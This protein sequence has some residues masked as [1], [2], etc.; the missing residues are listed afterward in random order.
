MC[1][2]LDEAELID[3]ECDTNLT[4]NGFIIESQTNRSVSAEILRKVVI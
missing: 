2:E 1:E 4:G 3:G